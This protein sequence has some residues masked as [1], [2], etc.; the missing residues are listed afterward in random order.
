M[1]AK[2]NTK[3]D[4]NFDGEPQGLELRGNLSFPRL[5]QRPGGDAGQPG[6]IAR[7]TD[8][9]V[10]CGTITG[11]AYAVVQGTGPYGDYNR[12]VG[13][14]FAVA[15]NGEEI[16]GTECFLPGIAERFV[17]AGLSTG[18]PV[19]VR[20]EGWA[21]P[22]P[23]QPRGYSY[24]VFVRQPPGQI[25]AAKRMAIEAGIIAA[26]S[27]YVAEIGYLKGD[28]RGLTPPAHDPE[29]GEVLTAE[30]E[31]G[32]TELLKGERQRHAHVVTGDDLKQHYKDGKHGEAV[33]A[34]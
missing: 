7:N 31:D 26:P 34:E 28:P 5:G 25:S 14:F 11:M 24:R 15:Y 4:D 22:D 30:Q 23:K 33:A 20:F 3:V 21:Y 13:E 8:R 18:N 1:T 29:T 12:I 9:P 17:L 6:A 27:G 16:T 32:L 2:V 10:R 19:P